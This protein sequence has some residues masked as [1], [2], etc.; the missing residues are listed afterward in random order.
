MVIN[1]VLKKVT[2]AVGSS[3]ICSQ[4]TSEWTRP[5]APLKKSWSRLWGRYA[6]L[7]PPSVTLLIM[8][9]PTCFLPRAPS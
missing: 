8:G 2:W 9:A 6:P 7:P 5:R 3:F 4:Y 1:R